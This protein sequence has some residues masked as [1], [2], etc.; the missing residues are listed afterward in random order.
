M[1]FVKRRIVPIDRFGLDGSEK[2]WPV[3]TLSCETWSLPILVVT[4]VVS[5][6]G[7]FASEKRISGDSEPRSIVGVENAALKFGSS[8]AD[9][10]D[11]TN[12]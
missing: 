12:G 8:G 9:S 7:N 4:S 3:E 1:T 2:N 10:S 6:L 5:L 11:S